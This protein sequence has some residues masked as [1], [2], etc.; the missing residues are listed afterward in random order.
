M[1]M[2][3]IDTILNEISKLG[4]VTQHRTVT[5]RKKREIKTVESILKM[6]RAAS[7]PRH[8]HSL[9]P[10]KDKS[11]TPKNTACLPMISL[12]KQQQKNRYGH[13]DLNPKIPLDLNM[14][15]QMAADEKD[16]HVDA[17]LSFHMKLAHAWQQ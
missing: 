1:Y 8:H 17:V 9:H 4:N 15:A 3:M 14:P 7:L 16:A 6:Q 11:T 5:E 13:F 12:S 2:Y 10:L